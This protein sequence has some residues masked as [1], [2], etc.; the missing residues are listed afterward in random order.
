M[1]RVG[2]K[3]IACGRASCRVAGLRGVT[4]EECGNLEFRMALST[5]EV[6]HNCQEGAS[7][8]VEVP[9]PGESEE[10]RRAN[11]FPLNRIVA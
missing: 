3:R 7:V 4:V 2:Y 6:R 9:M 11:V 1:E 5:E 8:V 10:S